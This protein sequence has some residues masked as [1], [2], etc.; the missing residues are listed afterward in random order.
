MTSTLMEASTLYDR[1]NPPPLQWQAALLQEFGQLS[2][3]GNEAASRWRPLFGVWAGWDAISAFMAIAASIAIFK[4]TKKRLR[5]AQRNYQSE[6]GSQDS[7]FSQVTSAKLNRQRRKSSSADTL[8]HHYPRRMSLSSMDPE[9]FQ[10]QQAAIERAR[11]DHYNLTTQFASAAVLFLVV[12]V[13]LLFDVILGYQVHMRIHLLAV[14]LLVPIIA[15]VTQGSIAVTLIIV[16]NVQGKVPISTPLSKS[17]PS[18]GLFKTMSGIPGRIYPREQSHG[19][20][21]VRADSEVPLSSKIVQVQFSQTKEIATDGDDSIINIS[22]PPSMDGQTATNEDS[23]IDM[24]SEKDV[25]EVDLKREI[26]NDAH[27]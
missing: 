18:I 20:V 21:R 2:R 15:Y 26:D 5:A 12:Q 3:Y 11:W 4:V 6:E 13:C 24:K 16:R 19:I 22:Y 23:Y 7:E 14:S 8:V 25:S 27:H 10:R 9:S 17:S 1:E